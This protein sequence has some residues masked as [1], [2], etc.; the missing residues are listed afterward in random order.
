MVEVEELESHLLAPSDMAGIITVLAKNACDGG[1]YRRFV[2]IKRRE[3]SAV[4]VA[5][6]HA[7]QENQE[8]D[9]K[10]LQKNIEFRNVKHNRLLA[11]MKRKRKL[12][13]EAS[14]EIQEKLLQNIMVLEDKISEVENELSEASEEMWTRMVEK[15]EDESGGVMGFGHCPS[16]FGWNTI[17]H[18]CLAFLRVILAALPATQYTLDCHAAQPSSRLACNPR[19]WHES[20]TRGLL[21]KRQTK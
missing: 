3:G 18:C 10:E 16:R 1:G 7:P 8:R 21:S 17:L 13:N 12:M 6:R 14:D 19:P 2:F 4:A 9:H 5:G 20:P 15:K 11:T